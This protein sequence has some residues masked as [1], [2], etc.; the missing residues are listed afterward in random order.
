MSNDTALAITYVDH[1][2]LHCQDPETW[3]LVGLNLKGLLVQVAGI[4]AERDRLA[5]ILAVERGDESQAPEGW[6]VAGG[7]WWKRAENMDVSAVL[8][9]RTPRG[10]D[11]VVFHGNVLGYQ[12]TA[13]EAMEAAD[14]ALESVGD[15]GGS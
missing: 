8:M 1:L 11:W 10:W 9:R 6:E 5:Q 2:R 4:E 12:P 15:G 13:L 14:A 7:M 3:P